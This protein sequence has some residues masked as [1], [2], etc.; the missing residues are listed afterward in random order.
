MEVLDSV[1]GFQRFP[2]LEPDHLEFV[3]LVEDED[4]EDDDWTYLF[5]WDSRAE[6]L[7]HIV[8]DF[9]SSSGGQIVRGRVILQLKFGPDD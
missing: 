7:L 9:L 8:V 2:V 5:R 1:D 3:S 6:C 4:E